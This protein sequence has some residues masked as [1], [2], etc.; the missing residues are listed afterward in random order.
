M[1]VERSF[2]GGLRGELEV[3]VGNGTLSLCSVGSDQCLVF[4][5]K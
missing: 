5:A 3:K 1:T 2:L 4:G